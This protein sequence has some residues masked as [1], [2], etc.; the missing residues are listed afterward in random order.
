MID[1]TSI[2]DYAFFQ[3]AFVGGIC[4]AMLC[5]VMGVFIVLRRASLIG[6][7]IAHL[8]FGGIALGLFSCRYIRCTRRSFSHCWALS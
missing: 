1:L 7:G 8:S 4:A 3:R 5:S 2:F 6:E